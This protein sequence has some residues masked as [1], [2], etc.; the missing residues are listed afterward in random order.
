MKVFLISNNELAYNLF[1][2]NES[3]LETK[4]KFRPLNEKGDN[5]AK[6]LSTQP[7]FQNL[8]RVY[9]AEDLASISTSIYLSNSL[10]QDLVVNNNLN[11]CKIG[12]LGNKNL[13][14]LSYFSEHNYDFKLEG[15]ESLNEC[16]RRINSFIKSLED[17]GYE[18]VGI[19]L[20]KRCLMAFLIPHTKQDFNLDDR[21]ILIY[22]ERIIYGDVDN[23][24]EMFKITYEN[25]KVI[26][27]ESI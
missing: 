20:P 27:I 12:E 11:E 14:M 16:S 8:E 4:L 18:S 22:N 9:S 7:E 5:L 1:F 24:L 15:G 26:D 3:N 25:N 2:E 19:F 17:D 10:S 23:S 13:K 21:L 6:K